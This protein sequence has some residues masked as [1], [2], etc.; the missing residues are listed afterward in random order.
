[1]IQQ[2]FV[3]LLSLTMCIKTAEVNSLISR[4]VSTTPI[5]IDTLNGANGAPPTNLD[6]NIDTMLNLLVNKSASASPKRTPDDYKYGPQFRNRG[7][8]L[9]RMRGRHGD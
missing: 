8:V 4:D 3:L 2:L 7:S 1:M 6:S 9:R 5:I